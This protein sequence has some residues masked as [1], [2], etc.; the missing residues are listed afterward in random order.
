VEGNW[1]F[2][3]I[4]YKG[5]T[6]WL[7]GSYLLALTFKQWIFQPIFTISDFFIYLF[8]KKT[9]LP[10]AI[11]WRCDFHVLGINFMA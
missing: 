3:P 8:K 9:I 7:E 11:R 1:F 6:N 2:G 10:L 4:Y 5:A